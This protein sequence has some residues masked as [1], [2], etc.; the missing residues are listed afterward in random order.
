MKGFGCA[1]LFLTTFWTLR[2]RVSNSVTSCPLG[3]APSIFKQ[4]FFFL[5]PL[6]N[7]LFRL[8]RKSLENPISQ[9]AMRM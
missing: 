5:W 3:E 1:F 2:L 6:R 9:D 8:V 4:Y 7:Y